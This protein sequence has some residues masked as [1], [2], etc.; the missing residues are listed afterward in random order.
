[1]IRLLLAAYVIVEVAAFWALAHFLG[2]GW[3]LLITLGAAALGYA[4]LGRRARGLTSDL[5]K[6]SR[7][8]VGAGRP[9]TDTAL[10]AGAALFTILPGVVSTIVGLIIMTPAARRALRPVIAAS[11]AKRA[12]LLVGGGP[13]AG[14]SGRRFGATGGGTVDGTV[15]GDVV[16]ETSDVEDITERNPDGTVRVE[17]PSLPRARTD[18]N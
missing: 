16:D 6:A 1:M 8:E 12:T 10:F 18:W 13:V 2:F 14:G 7:Q 4:L 15:E 5:R 17:R 11:A 9:L 3:A